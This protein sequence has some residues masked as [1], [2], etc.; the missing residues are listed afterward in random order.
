MQDFLKK[1]WSIGQL[2]IDNASAIEDIVS[3]GKWA[4]NAVQQEGG[5]TADD[6]AALKTKEDAAR[7]VLQG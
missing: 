3:F 4:L 2:M 6:W 7:A 5:P 1:A